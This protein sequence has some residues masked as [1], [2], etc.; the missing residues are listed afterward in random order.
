M[1]NYLLK[2]SFFSLASIFLFSN[3]V[4]NLS[5]QEEADQNVISEKSNPIIN[6]GS[7][8]IGIDINP[9]TNKLYVA[10]QFSN[11]I[12]VI[13]ID[14]SKVEKNIDV[15]NS[16]YDVDVNPFSNRIY[17]SNRDSDTISVI[18][19]FTNKELTDIKVGESP[20]GIGINLARGWVYV[21][22]FD[23]N[24]ITV[25]DAI[26]NRIRESLK[27]ASSPYDIVINP[28]T[29]KV[30][31]SDLGKDS[32]LVLDGNNNTLVS[33][34]PVGSKPS[35][36]AINTQTNT[37]YVSNFSNDSVSVINGTS[38]NV[39]TDIKVGNNPVG[40]GVNP[41]TNK[42]YV[43]N[44]VDNTVSVINGTTTKVIENISLEPAI[45]G[46]GVNTPFINIPLKVT[47]PLIA[48]KLAVDP[49]TNFTYVTN[50]RSNGIITIDGEADKVITKISID[51]NPPNAG[52]VKC[53]DI[54]LADGESIT[55]PLNSLAKCEAM[56]DRGY[57]FGHWSLSNST[58][59]N[60]VTFNVTGYDT[61]TA[62]FK[63]GILTET[64]IVLTSVIIGLVSTIGGWLYRQRSRLSF[65]RSLT[66]ID[67]T[68]EMLSKNN[69]EECIKQLE[70][71]QRDLN[72]L[73]RKGKI[74]ESQLE[75][76]EK[77]I[78]WYISRANISK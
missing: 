24:T 75:F 46:S 29:N 35:A 67:Y 37:I 65:K 8:P 57:D 43:N 28:L 17:T 23:S 76:L 10:N 56:P 42:I 53:N 51:I 52:I 5:A 78:N 4:I 6:S 62:N 69:K 31:V 9:I 2:F 39:E 30:Y 61:L 64:F 59:Q 45:I 12:S 73:H 38:N 27:Y 55:V 11:T 74:N 77:R 7:F 68:Y 58:N 44:L 48:S 22:N 20:L 36:L 49:I 72:F 41:R 54:I 33:T 15:G 71:I 66:N 34:I 14:N 18:D 3:F 70:Q 26:N 16:P 25:I 63:G 19:G 60:P 21:A 47:F 13:D 32:I 40:I 50:P 1:K